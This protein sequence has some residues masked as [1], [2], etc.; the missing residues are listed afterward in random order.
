MLESRVAKVAML[1]A[2]L[3]EVEEKIEKEQATMASVQKVMPVKIEQNN[4]N[5]S[6]AAAAIAS[7]IAELQQYYSIDFDRNSY[8]GATFDTP[9]FATTLVLNYLLLFRSQCRCTRFIV[10]TF[11]H[12]IRQ[13]SQ[14]HFVEQFVQGKGHATDDH[15]RNVQTECE[16]NAGGEQRSWHQ[17]ARLQSGNW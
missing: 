14:L 8:E 15:R 16:Q 3:A 10:G 11:A 17:C 13:H 1:Q 6:V 2:K 5:D 4:A 9:A 12:N 7:A